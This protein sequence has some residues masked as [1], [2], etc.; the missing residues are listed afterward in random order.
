MYMRI[1][2]VGTTWNCQEAPHIQSMV[3]ATDSIGM[4]IMLN[5]SSPHDG[6]GADDANGNKN[7]PVAFRACYET[8]GQAVHAEVGTARLIRHAGYEVDGLMAAISNHANPDDYCEDED[9]RNMLDV[10]WNGKYYGFNVHPYE[11]VFIKANRDIDTAMIDRLTDWHR[12]DG[13]NSWQACGRLP[14]GYEMRL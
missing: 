3:F 4:E 11:L 12:R 14:E 2:L 10:Q 1:Q 5:T 8:M 6:S 13:R 7:D 9:A